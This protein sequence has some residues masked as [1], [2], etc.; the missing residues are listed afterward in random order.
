MQFLLKNIKDGMQSMNIEKYIILKHKLGESL[1]LRYM[2]LPIITI[3]ELCISYIYYKKDDKDRIKAFKNRY[4]GKRCFIVGN[5]PSL[6]EMDLDLLKDEY[7][8]ATNRIYNIFEKTDWRPNFYVCVDP[9][10]LKE[11]IEDIK[12]MSN[13]VKF[14]SCRA[15]LTDENCYKI[16]DKRYYVINPYTDYKVEFSREADRYITTHSTV[17]YVAMQ[18]AVYMGFDAI[19]LLGFDH[20]FKVMTDKKNRIIV[21]DKVEKNHFAAQKESDQNIVF[22]ANGANRDYEAFKNVASVSNIKIINATRGG[23]LEIFQRENLEEVLDFD[24][25]K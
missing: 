11:N 21:N 13:T 16:N 24:N 25:G 6:S 5:G 19:V 22:D 23:C 9:I 4:K 12:K 1:I 18:L 7:T 2:Y 3:K 20:N 14:I 8:F 15:N 10:Q 17:S